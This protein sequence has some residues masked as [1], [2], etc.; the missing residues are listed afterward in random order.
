MPGVGMARDYARS[1]IRTWLARMLIACF[2]VL[3]WSGQTV[4]QTGPEGRIA[5][6][7]GN[8]RYDE[9]GALR[10][11]ANDAKLLAGT[12]RRLGF[13]VDLVVDADQKKMKR[14]VKLLGEKLLR[15]GP[16]AIGLFYFAGHGVQIAGENYLIPAGA[17]IAKEADVSIE[18]VAANDVLKQMQYAGNAVNLIFLDACR[19]NPMAR[20][21]R[22]VQ[23]G[24]A[25]VDAP[26]GSFVGYSTAPGEVAIDGAGD[27]SPYAIAL[28]EELSE[29]GIS[30]EVAHREVRRK[31]LK[32]TGDAQTPW[33]SSSLT[34][35]VILAGQAPAID[36]TMQSGNG[37]ALD[38]K[39]ARAK[40]T[41]VGMFFVASKFAGHLLIAVSDEVMYPEALDVARKTGGYLVNIGSSAE[42]DAVFA[43]IRNDERFW[44][45]ST[46]DPDPA[47]RNN[48]WA[49]GPWIG[50]YQKDGVSKSN[51]GWVSAGGGD[52]AYL[53]WF[54][55]QPNEADLG[56]GPG[57]ASFGGLN[58]DKPFDNWSDQSIAK[59][60]TP[61][62][63]IEIE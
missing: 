7:I 56:N 24:L 58:D 2:C 23:P 53:K 10:N 54:K 61:G 43:M 25:R 14:A 49:Q 16:S 4:A 26:R 6:V 1:A 46:M 60:K 8:S 42:N 5:L 27:N 11:P 35:E 29:P 59:G 32:M 63:V 52:A 47:S 50:L 48:G 55:G 28:A 21:F 34:G 20:G 45:N 38:A 15:A 41:L 30:I 13:D 12:L 44:W 9:L 19:N 37:A 3:A 51:L 62:Y 22:S 36:N 39:L 57:A 40:S 31:V 17:S 18:A 33:D